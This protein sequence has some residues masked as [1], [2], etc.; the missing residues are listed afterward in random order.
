MKLG[1]YVRS[2]RTPLEGPISALDDPLPALM[3]LPLMAGRA[4]RKV[5]GTGPT[6]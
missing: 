3:D 5:I 2:L 1:S 6:G 4:A